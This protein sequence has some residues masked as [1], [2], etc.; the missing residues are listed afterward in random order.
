M[1]ACVAETDQPVEGRA[2]GGRFTDFLRGYAGLGVVFSY[3]QFLSVYVSEQI[4]PSNPID[5]IVFLMFFLGL[6][7]FLLIAVIQSLITL[8][9]MREGRIRFVR[10]FAEKMGITDFV[11]ISFEKVNQH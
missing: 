1:H 4:I 6:P 10:N 11:E 9:I 2:V 8:D 7:I 5:I 3:L